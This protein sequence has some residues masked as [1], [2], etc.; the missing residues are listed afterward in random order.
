MT[1]WSTDELVAIGTAVEIDIAPIG[2]DGIAAR[3]TTIWVVEVD[4]HLYVRSYHG[5]DGAWYRQARGSHRGRITAGATTYEVTFVEPSGVDAAVIDAA[6]R[7]KY[8]RHGR[9]YVD[10]M[11][12]G[13][14]V[15]ATLRLDPAPAKEEPR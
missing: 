4:G 2:P 3:P 13:R 10:A 7:Q 9:S 15:A 14:A 5:P 12:N 11:V 6:Y 8:A 1:T